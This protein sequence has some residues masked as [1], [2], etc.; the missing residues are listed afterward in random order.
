MPE[1]QGAWLTTAAWMRGRTEHE[2]RK[3][4]RLILPEKDVNFMLK[5]ARCF[6]DVRVEDWT[7]KLKSCDTS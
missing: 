4:N 3:E 1:D 6:V 5:P 7:V 2:T